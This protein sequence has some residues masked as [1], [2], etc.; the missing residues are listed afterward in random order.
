[1]NYKIIKPINKEEC[2][3]WVVC[4]RVLFV[5]FDKSYSKC[6]KGIKKKKKV[7][8]MVA[9]PL[10]QFGKDTSVGQMKKHSKQWI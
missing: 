6:N 4:Q 3:N 9:Q 1:M 8:A 2:I 5:I 7:Y 10:L